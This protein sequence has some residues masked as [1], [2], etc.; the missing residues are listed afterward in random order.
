MWFYE[1]SKEALK[2][3]SLYSKMQPDRMRSECGRLDATLNE[4]TRYGPHQE[5]ARRSKGKPFKVILYFDGSF[6]HEFFVDSIEQGHDAMRYYVEK[7]L[8]QK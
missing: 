5:C 3:W 2:R 6:N 4:V 1:P 8:W 7:K